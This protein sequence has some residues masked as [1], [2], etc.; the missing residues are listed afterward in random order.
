M[1]A[2]MHKTTNINISKNNPPGSS[3][4]FSSTWSF[5]VGIGGTNLAFVMGF[6][7]LSK[8]CRILILNRAICIGRYAPGFVVLAKSYQRLAK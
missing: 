5:S 4:V 8:Y 1:P 6:S 3:H 7:A 2:D